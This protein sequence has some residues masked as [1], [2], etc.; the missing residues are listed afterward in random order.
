MNTK[1]TRQIVRIDETL[2][3][4]CG[5]CAHP[6][7]AGA[8]KIVDGKAR[9]VAERYCD[10]LGMCLGECP[11]GAISIELRES[12]AFDE[13]ATAH[14]LQVIRPASPVSTPAS[15]IRMAG[16]TIPIVAAKTPG[17]S[18]VNRPAQWPV[19]LALISPTAQVL[20]QS[21]LLLAADCVAFASPAFHQEILKDH[22]LLVACPKLDNYQAHL[23]EL[24]SILQ[25]AHPRSV[26][27]V[28]M[29]VPCCSGL[30]HMAQEALR[31]TGSDI[32]LSQVV[33][34]IDGSIR[35]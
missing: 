12:D 31:A 24:T 22:A 1:T 10:G 28:R 35:K 16:K 3:D 32:P 25:N 6:C 18:R 9:L 21:D 4:G 34:K 17:V 33:V 26:T 11:R 29:E 20:Q 15:S 30:V 8:I 23:S 5:Q 27:V 14:H 2:C 13:Q 19:Q 7:A